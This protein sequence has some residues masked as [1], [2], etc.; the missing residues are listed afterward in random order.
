MQKHVLL[1]EKEHSFSEISMHLQDSVVFIFGMKARRE[2]E[3]NARDNWSMISRKSYEL[4]PGQC[5]IDQ[6][7]M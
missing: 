7:I 1:A 6:Q 2:S 5:L 4:S 3:L